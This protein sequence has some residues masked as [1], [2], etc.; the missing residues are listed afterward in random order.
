MDRYTE[1]ELAEA[2]R[3]IGSALRRCRRIQP[4]FP[5]GTAQHTLLKNRI[6]ALTVA[7]G[8]LEGDR[9]PRAA[10][11]AALPPVASII[12]KCEAAQGKYAPGTGQY[13]RFQG[14]LTAMRVAEGL[15]TEALGDP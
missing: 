13:A 7:L 15:V 1:Q 9:Y 11:E 8:L 14:L 2:G 3:V 6:A 5:A 4:K 10:L 12:H